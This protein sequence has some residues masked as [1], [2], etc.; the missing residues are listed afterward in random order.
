M[1]ITVLGRLVSIL[2]LHEPLLTPVHQSFLFNG[3]QSFKQFPVVISDLVVLGL[4]FGSELL[5]KSMAQ[6]LRA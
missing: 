5:F 6:W 1:P 4:H 2:A 3:L